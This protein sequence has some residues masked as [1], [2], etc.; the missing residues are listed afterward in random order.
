MHGHKGPFL[1]YETRW[2]SLSKVSYHPNIFAFVLI[3]YLHAPLALLIEK[4]VPGRRDGFEKH[5][6]DCNVI[7]VR[8]KARLSAEASPSRAGS[9]EDSRQSEGAL[10]NLYRGG[11]PGDNCLS[12]ELQT[13]FESDI[14]KLW[15]ANGW[16]W[17]SINSPQTRMFFDAWRPEA[18]LPDRHK[19]SGPVLRSKVETANVLMR[20]AVKGQTTTGMS[21]G[22]KN[23]RRTSLLAS[24]LSVNYKVCEACCVC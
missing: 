17:N 14:C 16:S 22:W 8:A 21:D 5:I 2:N 12:K 10:P 20:E 18:K 24:M 23:I 11:T 15:I 3:L 19:L 13:R 6:K 9:L 1:L 4:P 7:D